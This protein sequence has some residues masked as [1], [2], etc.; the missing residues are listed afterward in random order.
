MRSISQNFLCVLYEAWLVLF[1]KKKKSK[2]GLCYKGHAQNDCSVAWNEV[3][4]SQHFLSSVVFTSLS[5]GKT[6]KSSTSRF[7]FFLFLF[8]VFFPLLWATHHVVE[9][10]ALL[11]LCFFSFFFWSNIFP[12][13]N[14]QNAFFHV[15]CTFLRRVCVGFSPCLHQGI[16]YSSCY[17][18]SCYL[19][20]D[21]NPVFSVL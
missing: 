12:K 21:Y 13:Q 3:D 15:P 2:V 7:M 14:V 6:W 5:S 8:L 1:K 20:N 18:A 16:L 9:I 4:I 10:K 17:F 19:I 11:C